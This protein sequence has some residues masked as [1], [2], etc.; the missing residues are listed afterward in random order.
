MTPDAIGRR[1]ADFER[2]LDLA[3]EAAQSL[4]RHLRDTTLER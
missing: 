2:V 4:L 1:P 3:E